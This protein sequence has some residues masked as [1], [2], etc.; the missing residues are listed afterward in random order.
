MQGANPGRTIL[1]LKT[2]AKKPVS[3][4]K[5]EISTLATNPSQGSS[6]CARELLE[7]LKLPLF[8]A[9]QGLGRVSY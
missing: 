9:K 7:K 6:H 2:K 8:D 5:V 4:K 1:N 3:Y